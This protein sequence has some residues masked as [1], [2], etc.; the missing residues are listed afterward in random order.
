MKMDCKEASVL[1]L[2]RR[3]GTLD[4][5]QV[6][7]LEAHLAGCERCRL[8]DAEDAALSAALE[9][10]PRRRAPDA[11]KRSLRARWTPTRKPSLS[12][13]RALGS[14][15]AGA[16]LAAALVFGWRGHSSSDGLFDEA[17]NDHLRILYAA[18]PI[19][20]ESGG[21]HQVKPWF[22]GRLDFAP[23]LAFGGDDD[24]PLEGGAVAYFMDRKAAAFEFKRRLHPITLLVF[25][26]DGLSWPSVLGSIGPMHAARETQRGFHVLLWRRE[27]LGY[28]L[29]SDLDERELIELGTKIAGE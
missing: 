15:A 2:D 9:R 10:L 18:R 25:R 22:A 1:L 28:A 23:V 12:M 4:L 16:A 17:V 7:D 8:D 14:V 24:Y 27:D 5:S 19:E 26:A 20:I 13:G 3:R 6:A 29:V 11:L 21:V